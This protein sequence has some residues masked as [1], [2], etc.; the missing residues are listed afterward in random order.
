MR[1]V[2]ELCDLRPDLCSIAIYCLLS[3]EDDVSAIC[4]IASE[5]VYAVA[6]VS[7]PANALSER[8]TASSAP[9]AMASRSAVS[10]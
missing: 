5:S 1:Y 4:P 7:E 9:M 8:R 6:Q 10:A 2:H 3:A